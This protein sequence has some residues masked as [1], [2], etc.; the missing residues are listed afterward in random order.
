MEEHALDNVDP[1][2]L[3]VLMVTGHETDPA[4]TP[5]ELGTILRHQLDTGLMFDLCP[6]SRDAKASLDASWTEYGETLQTFGQLLLHARPPL[7]LLL[8]LKD[9]GKS[10]RADPHSPLPKEIATALYYAAIA[11]ALARHGKSISQLQA[12]ELRAGM[13]WAAA[14]DWMDAS[15]REVFRDALKRLTKTVR[16]DNGTSVA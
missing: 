11:V 3:S 2:A 9:F 1:R 6:F 13:E 15:L 8:F 7:D 16:D 5:A 10:H 14:Q 12:A 4:W